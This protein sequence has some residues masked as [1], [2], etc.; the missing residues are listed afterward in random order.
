MPLALV[1]LIGGQ[2]YIRNQVS[3]QK[4][5][6]DAPSLLLLGLALFAIIYAGP[7]A[8]PGFCF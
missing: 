6:F 4:E 7:A 3:G 5:K 1:S 2:V 8:C